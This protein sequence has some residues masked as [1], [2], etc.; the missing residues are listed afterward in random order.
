MKLED[1]VITLEQA[2]ELQ[3]L[4]IYIPTERVWRQEYNIQGM[5]GKVSWHDKYSLVTSGKSKWVNDSP[6][7]LLINDEEDV[8]VY[9]IGHDYPAP[10]TDE[11]MACLPVYLEEKETK[12]L[13]FLNLQKD[14][15][16]SSRKEIYNVGY[17]WLDCYYPSPMP[18]INS[19]KAQA[20]Y[21]MLIYLIKQGY[22]KP[23]EVGSAS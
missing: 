1:K 20:L 14:K 19:N 2:K 9:Y 18:F 8:N 7:N 10:D 22:I 4:M 13:Y 21:E 12:T 16:T 6:S 5:S 23:E 17:G 15:E 11:L 3:K